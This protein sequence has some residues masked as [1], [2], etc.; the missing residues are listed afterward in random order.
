MK[1]RYSM[2]SRHLRAFLAACLAATVLA[3]GL[4]AQAADRKV[5]VV[6]GSTS[7]VWF[8]LYVA[9]GAGYFKDEGLDVEVVRV[10]ANST[11][12]AAILG[13]NA[14]IGGIGPQA[15]F[16]AMEKGQPIKVLVS[17]AD[18][19]TSTLFVRKELLKEK[20]V[21]RDS[22]IKD[23]VKALTGLKLATTAIGAG[24]HLMYRYLFQHYA[25]GADVDKVATIVP[26][27]DASA[28]LAGMQ[29][30]LVDASAF[31]PP[32]PEKAVADGY[33]EVLIDFIGGDVPAAQDMIYATMSVTEEKLKTDG[34]MLA[35][36]VR[37]IDR[38]N[39][40]AQQDLTAAGNAARGFMKELQSDLYASAVKAM[41]P[42]L[43]KSTLVSVRG[44]DNAL[45][46]LEVGGYK[47][48][49]VDVSKLPV[50]DFIEQAL[51]R[52]M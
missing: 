43:P 50:N 33:A 10:A 35:A 2:L 23:R 52:K 37:A 6:V 3:F 15:V 46:L 1:S 16:A 20:G 47:F 14:D 42:A 29:R 49:N 28:T 27:G 51:A 31:T 12:V 25:D 21:T 7:F 24:P 34:P 36:F 8:P 4:T 30:G 48:P 13:G 32:V 45:K 38:A 39:K 41:Q 9:H 44:L 22:P 19:Y 26:I 17:M 40:L 11:P 5:T 18:A